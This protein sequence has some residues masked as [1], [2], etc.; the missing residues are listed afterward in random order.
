MLQFDFSLLLFTFIST[1]SAIRI[2]RVMPTPSNNPALM[3]RHDA[4]INQKVYNDPHNILNHDAWYL[5]HAQV[6][7]TL[8]DPLVPA[9]ETRA[10]EVFGTPAPG[11]QNTTQGSATSVSSLQGTITIK[12]AAS[13]TTE[14]SN[15]ID[16]VK[17]IG[18]T[19]ALATLDTDEGEWDEETN[20]ACIEALQASQ[21]AA[22]SFI[23]Y[24]GVLQCEEP[25]RYDRSF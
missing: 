25:K 5:R 11:R 4:Y 2:A 7:Q 18:M 8:L 23:G 9:N 21:A 12:A 14:A 24:G 15:M 6:N 20:E 1:T 16:S 13:S 10:I 3:H 22:A 17:A 19:E